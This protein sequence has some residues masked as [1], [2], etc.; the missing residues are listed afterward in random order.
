M[1]GLIGLLTIG[2]AFTA[3]AALQ[4]GGTGATVSATTTLMAA[5]IFV[6]LVVYLPRRIQE[7]SDLND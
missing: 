7:A 5:A 4:W 3:I 6:A 1:K 2:G